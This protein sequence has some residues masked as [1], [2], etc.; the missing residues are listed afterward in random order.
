MTK[1]HSI[2]LPEELIFHKKQSDLATIRSGIA[3]LLSVI[4]KMVYLVQVTLP[5]YL[6][7]ER[8]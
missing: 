5:M 2:F 1:N 4:F 6:K 7:L 3:L 8:G